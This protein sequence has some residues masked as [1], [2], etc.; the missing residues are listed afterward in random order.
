MRQFAHLGKLTSGLI[1]EL[2]NPLT[3]VSLNLE[4]LSSRSRRLKLFPKYQQTLQE[5]LKK[6]RFATQKIEEYII[7]TQRQLQQQ[8]VHER[9]S[10]VEE[11]RHSMEMFA[12]TCKDKQIDMSVAWKCHPYLHGNRTQFSH[13]VSNLLSNACDACSS[14]LMGKREI[15]LTIFQTAMHIC[16]RVADTGIGIPQEDRRYI[17]DPFF[18]TKADTKGTGLGLAMTRDIMKHS[19]HG[20][21]SVRSRKNAGTTFTLCFPASAKVS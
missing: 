14:Q 19:F 20:T 21:I 18:T 4:Q 10:L 17:F 15:T 7:C 11:I 2:V 9:F 13:C 3:V 8:V 16:V 6:A 1:H 5:T 12:H